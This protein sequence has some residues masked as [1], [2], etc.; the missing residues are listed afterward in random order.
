MFL[1]AMPL[2]ERGSSAHLYYIKE[3]TSHEVVVSLDSIPVVQE[4]TYVFQEIP[5]LPPSREIMFVID[6]APGTRPIAREP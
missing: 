5:G 6:L 2:L 4:F 1:V 3:E